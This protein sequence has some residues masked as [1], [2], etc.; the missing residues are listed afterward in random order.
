MFDY[1]QF[2][3]R[4]LPHRHT[5]GGTLFVTFRLAGSFPK[6]LLEHYKSEKIRLSKEITRIN[7]L[8]KDVNGEST[9]S[10]RQFYR[11]W[12][13]K[14]EDILHRETSGPVWLKNPEVADM[15]AESLKHRDGLHYDLK[16]FCI[17]SNH[18]HTVIKPMLSEKTLKEVRGS[19]P[20][21]FVSTEPTISAIMR[22]LKGFTARQA[23]Q[24]LHRSGQFWEAE[25]YDH[26]VRNDEELH[27]IVRY[28]L[29]N[30]VKANLVKDWGDWKWNWQSGT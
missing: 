26:E 10:L 21:R 14:F 13:Q 20:L 12:F 18:V 15:V 16:A 11:N 3:R 30:P 24:I 7:K 17:M 6:T 22:S 4:K 8:D 29:N 23:N 9:E 25:S 2:Y 19:N 27:R 1:K 5:P 28:V